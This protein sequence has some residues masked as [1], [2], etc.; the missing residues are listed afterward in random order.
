MGNS[1]GKPKAG[2]EQPGPITQPRSQGAAQCCAIPG[3][4][5]CT[6]FYAIAGGFG[7]RWTVVLTVTR[8]RDSTQ[9]L[10]SNLIIKVCLLADYWFWCAGWVPMQ[11]SL[12]SMPCESKQMPGH[13][14]AVRLGA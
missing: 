13:E 3:R 10:L 6:I 14:A 8:Q 4:F 11:P 7:F 5:C 12:W 2:V 1:G 9:S